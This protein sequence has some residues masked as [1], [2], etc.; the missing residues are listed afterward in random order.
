MNTAV[1]KPSLRLI[2]RTSAL[3]L[4]SFVLIPVAERLDE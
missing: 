4:S 1:V 2:H 3:L